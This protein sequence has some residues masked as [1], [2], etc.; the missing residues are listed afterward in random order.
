MLEKEEMEALEKEHKTNTIIWA[1]LFGSLLVYFVLAFTLGGKTEP[2]ASQGMDVIAYSLMVVSVFLLVLIFTIR[3]MRL[4]VTKDKPLSH[5]PT[6]AFRR[7]LLQF[8]ITLI[9]TLALS[10]AIGLY[11]LVM[12]FI[13]PSLTYLY[14][15]IGFA[16]A[17]FIL[18]RP[19]YFDL[20]N[21]ASEHKKIAM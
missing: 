20:E 16:A 7:A 13:G 2:E 21:F 4:S 1:A 17:L 15:F 19:K 11:G 9:I 14:L 18:F 3:K 12:A 10:E 5:T 6:E 8:R